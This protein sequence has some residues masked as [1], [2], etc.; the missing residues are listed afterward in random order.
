[1]HKP[2][3]NNIEKEIEDKYKKKEKRK[4][5]VMKVSGGNVKKLQEIIRKKS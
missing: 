3:L 5:S 1:M 2:N 4:K